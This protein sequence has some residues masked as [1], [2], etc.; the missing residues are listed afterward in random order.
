MK[1]VFIVLAAVTVLLLLRALVWR[2]LF[3]FNQGAKMQGSGYLSPPPS[4]FARAFLRI[5]SAILRRLV[6]GP[7]KVYGREHLQGNGRQIYVPNHTFPLDFTLV[8]KAT[9]A[10]FRFMTVVTELKGIRGI[11]GAWTG[12]IPVN[13]KVEGGGEAAVKACIEWL[14]SKANAKLLAFPQGKLVLD[15]VLNRAD[16]KTGFARIAAGV[17]QLKPGEELEIVPIGLHYIEDTNR[18][19]WWHALTKP[20]RRMFGKSKYGA[21][22]VIGEPIKIAALPTDVVAATDLIFARIEGLVNQA[23]QLQ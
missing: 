1:I 4:I 23:R 21:V 15:N 6:V 14:T 9:R 18:K 5:N 2:A 8:L 16:F 12:A 3:W 10:T 13:T 22:V 20:L 11:L 17:E 7:V 19:R